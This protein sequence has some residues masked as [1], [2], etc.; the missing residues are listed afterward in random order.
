MPKAVLAVKV[1]EPPPAQNELLP[2]IVG[3]PGNGLTVM[4][5]AGVATIISLFV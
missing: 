5:I 1:V 3:V 2:I 4:L